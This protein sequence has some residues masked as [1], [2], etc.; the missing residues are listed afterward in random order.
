MR[1]FHSNKL[2]NGKHRYTERINFFFF[3]L[4]RSWNIND[5]EPK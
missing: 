2:E 3:V 1:N 5:F 4:R